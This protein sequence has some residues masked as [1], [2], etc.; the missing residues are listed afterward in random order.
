[1]YKLYTSL[2]TAYHNWGDWG[3]IQ[4]KDDIFPI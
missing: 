4:Y 2:T 1:M 3:L